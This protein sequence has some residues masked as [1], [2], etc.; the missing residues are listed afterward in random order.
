[1]KNPEKVMDREENEL[2]FFQEKFPRIRMEKLK[3][4]KFDSLQIRELVK[5]QIFK[6][7]LNCLPDNH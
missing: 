4:G 5:D 3:A 6:K 7:A 2:A 1:M